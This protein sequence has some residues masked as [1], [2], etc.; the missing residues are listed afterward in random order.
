[1]KGE[2]FAVVFTGKAF[3]CVIEI[4]VVYLREIIEGLVPGLF[5]PIFLFL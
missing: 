4:V 1:M 3:Q 5:N 2:L